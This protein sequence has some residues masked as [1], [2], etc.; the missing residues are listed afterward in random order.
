MPFLCLFDAGFFTEDIVSDLWRTV[1]APAPFREAGLDFRHAVPS[2][3]LER[4]HRRVLKSV[5]I[6]KP[7]R[8]AEFHV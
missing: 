7:Q 8:F 2:S 4:I 1:T 3:S 6:K 5:Y